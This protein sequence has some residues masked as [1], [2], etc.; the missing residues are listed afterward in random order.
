MSQASICREIILLGGFYHRGNLYTESS[1]AI[2]TAVTI[3][4]DM[5]ITW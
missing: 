1:T 4:I 5:E 3:G 2:T